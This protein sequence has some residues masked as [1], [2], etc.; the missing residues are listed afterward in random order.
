MSSE[1]IS[2]PLTFFTFTNYGIWIIVQIH[3]G[4]QNLS[5]ACE[6]FLESCS[7]PISWLFNKARDLKVMW[8]L[9]P[10]QPYMHSQNHFKTMYILLS[11]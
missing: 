4:V 9:K 1:N 7:R 8:P 11:K 3:T 5:C 6:G 2:Q 10:T